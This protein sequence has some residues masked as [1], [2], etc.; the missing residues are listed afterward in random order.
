MG[1]TQER[2]ELRS[3]KHQKRSSEDFEGVDQLEGG[4]KE[5]GNPG[6]WRPLGE[7]SNRDV[8]GRVGQ[9]PRYGDGEWLAWGTNRQNDSL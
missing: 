4:G 1:S 7:G 2:G 8:G 9:A 6:V 3:E 5:R